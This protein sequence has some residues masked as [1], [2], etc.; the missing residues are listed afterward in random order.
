MEMVRGREEIRRFTAETIATTRGELQQL[1]LVEPRAWSSSGEDEIDQALLASLATG[2]RA[3]AVYASEG[4]TVPHVAR[5]LRRYVGAGE[6]SR[7]APTLPCRLLLV[8]GECALMPLESDGPTTSALVLRAPSLMAALGALFEACW[9][10]GAPL[11]PVLGLDGPD[12]EDTDAA[13]LSLLAAGHQ[14]EAAARVLGVSLRTV[15]RR[16]AAVMDQLGA[17]TRFQAG[18]LAAQEGLVR[19]LSGVG[20]VPRRSGPHP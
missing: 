14:D 18:L 16:V 13:L 12:A 11:A 5:M 10:A 2:R 1:V 20:R 4:V 7:V 17:T 6:R 9:D 15:R 19:P 3:R 8:V